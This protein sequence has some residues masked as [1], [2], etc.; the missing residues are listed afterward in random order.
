[1]LTPKFV[2]AHY[3]PGLGGQSQSEPAMFKLSYEFWGFCVNGDN[4]LTGAIGSAKGFPSGGINMPTGFERGFLHAS[5]SDGVTHVGFPYFSS[6][7]GNFTSS[8]I[9]GKHLVA[10]QS[11]STSTDDSIYEILQVVNTT[12]LRVNVFQGG[13]PTSA[14]SWVPTFSERANINYRI[15]DI[16]STAVLNFPSGVFLVYNV[17]GAPDVNAGQLRSQVRVGMNQVGSNWGLRMSLSPS[18]SFN[19]SIFAEGQNEFAITTGNGGDW[20]GTGAA[21]AGY[22]TLVGAPDFLFVQ[23]C[24]ITYGPNAIQASAGYYF[25]IPE[26]LYPQ[27]NDPNPIAGTMWGNNQDAS[28]TNKGWNVFNMVGQ[29]KVLRRYDTL[30]RCPTGQFDQNGSVYTAGA[31]QPT[32]RFQGLGFNSYTNFVPFMEA[33]LHLKVAS[34]WCMARCRLRR[35]RFYVDTL[36]V[37]QI[38]GQGNVNSWYHM[39]DTVWIPWD[40]ARIPGGAFPLGA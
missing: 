31:G 5:G 16:A 25:E 32:T 28:T 35:I 11:G 19:G 37:N 8:V 6:S 14:S 39:F 9:V 34:Q 3:E 27:V 38:V 30:I 36:N 33:V 17:N 20:G 2:R 15:V 29:D 23:S 26:R 4:D 12:T 7:T 10:W 1:M 21:G 40:G 22:Y 24:G 13:T 18:G